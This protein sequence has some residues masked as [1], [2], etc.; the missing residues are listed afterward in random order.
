MNTSTG[1]PSLRASRPRQVPDRVRMGRDR[2]CVLPRRLAASSE[3]PLSRSVHVARVPGNH[4]HG[5]VPGTGGAPTL[6]ITLLNKAACEGA[7]PPSTDRYP[8][9]G[10][11]RPCRPGHPDL[12]FRFE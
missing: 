6:A 2:G 10:L 12:P 4:D 8:L 9:A 5:C 7:P 11:D 1:K 3:A